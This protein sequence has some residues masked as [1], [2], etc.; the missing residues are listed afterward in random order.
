M[1]PPALKTCTL[2]L[3]DLA[4]VKGHTKD[5]DTALVNTS[6]VTDYPMIVLLGIGFE[7]EMCDAA[8]RNLKD[9]LGPLAYIVPGTGGGV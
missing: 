6:E 3:L 8:D 7:A 1:P 4:V 5:V 2:L 9:A